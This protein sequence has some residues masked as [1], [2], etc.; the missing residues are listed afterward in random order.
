[1]PHQLRR[2][3]MAS[4]PH[5]LIV[6][7]RFYED[8]ADE[9]LSGA[10]NALD[11]AGATHDRISVPGALEIPA[12][13]AMAL[14]ASEDNGVEYDGFVALG[15]VIRGETSHY[16]IV[17]GESARALMDLAIDECI[18]VGNGI[19]TCENGEQAWARARVTE[20]NKGGGAAEAA[21]EMIR[22]RRKLGA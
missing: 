15:C 21:L 3:A 11:S 19:I 16:D 9:L 12:A 8:I 7:A 13:I 14:Y 5:L 18:A 17:A 10:V 20:K 1:M 2:F 4:A 6:E 22:V